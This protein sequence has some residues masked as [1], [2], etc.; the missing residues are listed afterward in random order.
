MSN[1]TVQLTLAL[2]YDHG[3]GALGDYF[4][5][6]ANGRAVAGQCTICG[7]VWFPPHARCPEDGGACKAVDLTGHG[8]VVG[9]TRTRTRLPFTDTDA[10][11]TF[12]LIAMAGADNA[13]FGRLENFE[14]TDATGILVRLATIHGPVGHPAQALIFEPSESD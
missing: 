13:A 11:R 6:L 8:V 2:D 1:N 14:G 7:R 5:G 4:R 12:V 10:E 3:L 9:E